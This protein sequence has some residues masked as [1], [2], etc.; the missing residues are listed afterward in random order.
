MLAL[1]L[2]KGIQVE[3]H[4]IGDSANRFT[5]DEYEKAFKAVRQRKE[6]SPNR[7]GV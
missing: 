1:A 7:V 6:K 5:L 3:T 2:E 4:A